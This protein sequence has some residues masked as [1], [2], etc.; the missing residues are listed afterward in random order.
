MRKLIILYI[1]LLLL[2]SCLFGGIVS[3]S[4]ITDALYYGI[5]TVTNN[6]TAVSAVG[7]NVSFGSNM[8]AQGWLNS[9]ANNC[10]IQYG[11]SDIPFMPGYDT[12]P[13]AIFVDSMGANS[14]KQYTLYTDDAVG[15]SI[16]YFPSGTG[17]EITDNASLEI[18]A[19]DILFNMNCFINTDATHTLEP[20]W[21]KS[22]VIGLYI[23]ASDNVSLDW[24]PGPTQVSLPCT[25]GEHDISISANATHVTL[26]IDTNSTTGVRAGASPNNANNWYIGTENVTTYIYSA[27][28][29]IGGT[30]K[31]NFEWEYNSIFIDT[32]GNGY[33]ATPNFRTTSTDT[34]VTAALTFFAPITQAQAP[35]F[36]VGTGPEWFSGNITI[37]GNFTSGNV[38]K[39]YPGRALIESL[40]TATSTPSQ[41][42]A[43]IISGF[44][45]LALSL[46]TSAFL[47]QYGTV[48]IL[49][50]FFVLAAGFGVAIALN[51]YDFWMMFF[52]GVFA[53]F[54]LFGSKEKQ[55]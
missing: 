16:V 36:V 32:L 21:H 51:I 45:I 14:Q 39:N 50:K 30:P 9:S 17:M 55:S 31:Y 3:G 22:A 25:T 7:A 52:L 35:A 27:N 4:D 5:I 38:T 24:Y 20:F 47:R 23:G 46:T 41:L 11:G 29:S 33:A 54:V 49:A 1:V 42:P 10:A 28:F 18:G 12:N 43:T 37:S 53:L 13:W 34:D 48:S 6:G 8:V 2:L 15:G 19:S 26:T 44:V 40:S